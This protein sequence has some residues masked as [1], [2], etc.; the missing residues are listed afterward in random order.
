MERFFQQFPVKLSEKVAL[1]M[2]HEVLECAKEKYKE[3]DE[4][5]MDEL[6]KL[7]NMLEVFLSEKEGS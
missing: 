2:M 7:Y 4:A 6:N 1:K 3:K 5:Y